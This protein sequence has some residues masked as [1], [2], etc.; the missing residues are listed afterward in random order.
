MEKSRLITRD[1]LS[2]FE[3]REEGDLGIIEGRPVVFNERTD[4]GL[5]DEII[6]RGAL[7]N[8]DMRD[9]RL[10]LN[11]DTSYVYA[12]SRNNNENSTMQIGVDDMGMYFRAGLDVKN[13][14]K[15]QDYYAAIQR[16]D[17][18]KM[19]FMFVIGDEKWEGLDTD[20]PTRIILAI[21]RIVEISAVTFPA[22][23]G[24]S[25]SARYKE[26]LEN[27]RQALESAK[28]VL[29]SAKRSLDSDLE[30]EKAKALAKILF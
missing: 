24:T 16:R 25:I 26:S 11:H 30:L 7:A 17:I 1:Y 2:T 13:S 22:Y 6:D 10:C 14:P 23:D 8:T 29:E 12:R 5:F 20:H 28:A 4:L 21:E 19:S 18:D 3:T 9:V 27:D 15:A